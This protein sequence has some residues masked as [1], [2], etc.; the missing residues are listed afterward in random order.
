MDSQTLLRSP[1]IPTAIPRNLIE[2][3]KPPQLSE[4][5]GDVTNVSSDPIATESAV[6]VGTGEASSVAGRCR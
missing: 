5:V 6:S 3:Y 4:G 2:K 1:A